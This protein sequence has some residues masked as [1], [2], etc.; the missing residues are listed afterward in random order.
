[1]KVNTPS[2]GLT[3]AI[4][5]RLALKVAHARRNKLK[6]IRKAPKPASNDPQEALASSHPS[7]GKL[8]M[9]S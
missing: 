2:P 9:H 1:M 8:E 7:K 4:A 3:R 6:P 5:R